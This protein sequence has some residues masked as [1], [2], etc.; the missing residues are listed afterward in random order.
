MLVMCGNELRGGPSEETTKTKIP[1][2]LH[3]KDL[4]AQSQSQTCRSK[5][6]LSRYN[7]KILAWKNSIKSINDAL[8]KPKF[9]RS[10]P[11]YKIES[12]KQKVTTDP[13]EMY[14]TW[15]T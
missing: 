6:S 14:V 15:F 1:S 7:W 3:D 13:N 10:T 9:V 5:F 2:V 11:L 12:S 4:P 8:Q